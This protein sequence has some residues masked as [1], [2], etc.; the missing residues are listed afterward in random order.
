MMTCINRWICTNQLT[1]KRSCYDWKVSFEK[2]C[3]FYP[4]NI[5]IHM[6][7]YECLIIVWSYFNHITIRLL[8]LL[9]TGFIEHIKIPHCQTNYQSLCQ[10]HQIDLGLNHHWYDFPFYSFL[11]H[12]CIFPKVFIRIKI[13]VTLIKESSIISDKD[14]HDSFSFDTFLT[15]KFVLSCPKKTSFL[16]LCNY[17]C[18]HNSLLSITLKDIVFLLSNHLT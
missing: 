6:N 16:S 5:Q 10:I 7:F 9:N 8:I 12:I 11:F 4:N 17:H 3:N 18:C 2:C 13:F 1:W 15:W 14:L